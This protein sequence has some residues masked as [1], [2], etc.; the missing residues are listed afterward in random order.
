MSQLGPTAV[1]FTVLRDPFSIF[2]SYYSYRNLEKEL[3]VD[4]K[5]FIQ[6]LRQSDPMNWNASSVLSAHQITRAVYE[7]GLA[8]NL[9][10]PYASLQDDK[11]IDNHIIKIEK[12][13]DLVMI[14]ERME[15]SLILFRYLMCWQPEDIVAFNQ[16]V[17]RV[18]KVVKLDKED[19]K[20]L[21]RWLKADQKIYNHFA[22]I[23]EEKV[24]SYPGDIQREMLKRIDDREQ[25]RADCFN[26]K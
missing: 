25:L 23:L 21:K 11:A 18:S 5:G 12:E 8:F 3:G 19:K 2:E 17:R 9:G 7:F 14:S 15:E 13:M 1:A 24:D 6:L 20:E 4:L 26:F 10:M 16:N 22:K